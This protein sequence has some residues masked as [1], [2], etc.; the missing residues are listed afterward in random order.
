MPLKR[1]EAKEAAK[2]LGIWTAPDSNQAQ[3]Y[4]YLLEKAKAF[5]TKIRTQSLL[6]RNEA[7]TNFTHTISKT[8]AY[9]MAA[10]IISGRCRGH[11]AV[12]GVCKIGSKILLNDGTRGVDRTGPRGAE[13]GRS[14]V[15]GAQQWE[16]PW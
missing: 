6:S 5:A 15:S 10:A 1:L 14:A 4:A 7:W 16:N 8:M 9:P 3:Q 2:Q 12:P 13:G 11:K